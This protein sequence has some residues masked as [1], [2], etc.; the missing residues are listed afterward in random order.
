MINKYIAMG[1][2]VADPITKTF[3]SGKSKSNFSIGVSYGK[4]TTWIEVECW[5]K[6]SD[7]CNSYLKKG[8]L[9]FVEGKMKYSSWVDKNIKKNKLIC[10]C[11]FF[12][13]LNKKNSENKNELKNESISVNNIMKSKNNVPQQDVDLQNELDEIPW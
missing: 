13:I 1:Y 5:D 12:K 11:D 6:I 3:Q 2:A 8:D 10:V 9:V 4:D 7:N